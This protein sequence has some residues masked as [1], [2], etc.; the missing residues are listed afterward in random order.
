MNAKIGIATKNTSDNFLFI[1]I[2]ITDAPINIVSA[3]INILILIINDVC[4]LLTSL[5]SLVT[6]DDV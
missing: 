2:A 1:K 6:N 5:V 3:L 4:A